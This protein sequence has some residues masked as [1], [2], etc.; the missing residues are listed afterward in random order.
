MSTVQVE[1]GQN[2]PLEDPHGPGGHGDGHDDHDEIPH[3]PPPSLR[4][5]I[6]SV[7]LMFI[8]YGIVFFNSGIGLTV[9]A[10]GLLIF[11]VGLGGWIYD[12]I[13]EARRQNA[14][15]GGHH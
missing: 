2:A 12:D 7:G 13:Q 5:L 10:I 1:R 9:G 4:P 14:E 11:A 3:L 15:G 6:M 8:A